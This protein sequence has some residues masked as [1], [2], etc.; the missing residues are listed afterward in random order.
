MPSSLRFPFWVAVTSLAV[1]V[2][3]IGAGGLRAQVA[4]AGAPGF[5]FGGP[6]RANKG[7]WSHGFGAP[8][9]DLR[10]GRPFT[11]EVTPGTVTAASSTGVTVQVKDGPTRSF[12]VDAQTHG[13]GTPN[14][15]E[16]VVVVTKDG[17]NTALAVVGQ[18]G[19]RGPWGGA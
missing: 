7:G 11:I 10:G 5:G 14:V 16:Q 1:V 8:F 3:L 4:Y 2:G 17:A 6:H 12:G 18:H 15:G 13:R 9:A 19:G